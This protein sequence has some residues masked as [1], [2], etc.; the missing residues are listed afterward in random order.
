MIGRATLLLIFLISSI[1]AFSIFS[2]NP[3]SPASSKEVRPTRT[4]PGAMKLCPPGG[5]SFLDAYNLICPMKRRRRSVDDE[6]ETSAYEQ[7]WQQFLEPRSRR[8]D[9]LRVMTECCT[10]GC[11]FQEIFPLCNPF[12]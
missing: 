8:S 1:A 2:R 4:K 9:R 12:N 3:P 11:T 6:A 10:V 5:Q 7:P